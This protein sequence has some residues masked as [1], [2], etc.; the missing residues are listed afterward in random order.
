MKEAMT[1]AVFVAIGAFGGYQ[2]GYGIGEADNARVHQKA[3]EEKKLSGPWA[4]VERSIDLAPGETFRQISITSRFGPGI[5][6]PQC[7][8]YTNAEAKVSS[9]VCPGTDQMTLAPDD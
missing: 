8:I 3:A 6:D 9:I 2:L 4:K 5:L 1:I 7:L